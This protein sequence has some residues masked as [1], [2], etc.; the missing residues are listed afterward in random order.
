MMTM[1]VSGGD[2]GG[3]WSLWLALVMMVSVDGMLR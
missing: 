1:V 2:D 3:W